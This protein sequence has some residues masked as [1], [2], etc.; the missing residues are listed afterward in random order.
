[1][2]RKPWEPDLEEILAM[3]REATGQFEPPYDPVPMIELCG[4]IVSTR[5]SRR[6]V[7][8]WPMAE[9]ATVNM[10]TKEVI[11]NGALPP[12]QRRWRLAHEL[13]HI[14]EHRDLGRS[15]FADDGHEPLALRREADAAAEEALIP[16]EELLQ[17]LGENRPD[18]T[19]LAKHFGTT[20][21]VAEL[22]LARFEPGRRQRR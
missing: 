12:D 13:G 18:A 10:Q 5:M 20:Q 2:E 17:W 19:K 8:E 6:D 14:L 16:A 11:V 4:F 1:V 22:R 7:A 21:K 15:I 9:H 3:A